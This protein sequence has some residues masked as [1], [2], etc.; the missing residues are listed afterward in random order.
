MTETFSDSFLDAVIDTVLPGE[1]HSALGPPLPS[2]SAAGLA[3]RRYGSRHA[4]VLTAIAQEAAKSQAVKS[5]AASDGLAAAGPEQRRLI[6]AAVEQVMF[7]PFRALV[8]DIVADYH[9]QPA[10]LVAYGWRVEP[11]QPHGHRIAAADAETLA[12][13]ERVKAR[14]PLWRAAS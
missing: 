2:A 10:V 12:R 14:G 13:L 1:V 3:G 6:L 7:E 9:D 4:A 11:P 5:Q 8:Q